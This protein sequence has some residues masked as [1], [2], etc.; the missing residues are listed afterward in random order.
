MHFRIFVALFVLI[1]SSASGRAEQA[2]TRIDLSLQRRLQSFYGI[3]FGFADSHLDCPEDRRTVVVANGTLKMFSLRFPPFEQLAFRTRTRADPTDDTTYRYQ[4]ANPAC[5]MD[6]DIRDQV[7]IG[8]QWKP[9]LVRED[10]RPSLPP[11]QRQAAVQKRLADLVK[12]AEAEARQD[13]MPDAEIGEMVGGTGPRRLAGAA[14]GTAF[15]FD[16]APQACMDAFGEYRITS[17]GFAM[18]FFAPLP[19][20]LNKFVLEGS[21]LDASHARIYLVKDDCRF[22]FTISLSIMHEG[23]W[24]ALPL[25]PA[26]DDVTVGGVGSRR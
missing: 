15:P 17:N 1:G 14:S 21:E 2:N 12:K 7:K 8:E 6:I 5:R 25:R 16:G 9:L 22:E 4:F 24:V 3:A 23:Q 10:R 11:D 26:R 20:A 18:A 13:P 19:G